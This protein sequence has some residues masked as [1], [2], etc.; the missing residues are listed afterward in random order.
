MSISKQFNS[1]IVSINS[2]N[3]T[4]KKKVT[5]VY[6]ENL[7]NLGKLLKKIKNEKKKY[8]IRTGK[9]SYD[10]KSINPDEKTWR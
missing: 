1:K 8:V 6:P 2:W 5:I 9:C 3:N 10:S 4:Y 7:K